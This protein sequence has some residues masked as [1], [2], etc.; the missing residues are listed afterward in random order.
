MRSSCDMFA[1][2]SDLYFDETDSSLAFSSTKRLASSTSWYLPSTSR[3]LS[4]SSAACSASPWFDSCSCSW[5]DWSS[6]A[7]DRDCS[8]SMSVTDVAATVLSTRPMLS[9][10]WSSSDWWVGLKAEKEASSITARTE[11][12][13]RI[14]S[15]MMFSGVASPRPELIWM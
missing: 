9:A 6:C 14:G 3:F 7:C 8:S 15:T 12:S 10:S 13:K 11:P 5:R 2:N 1:M 4:A